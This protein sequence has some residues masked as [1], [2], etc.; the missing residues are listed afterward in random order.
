MK[1]KEVKSI[2]SGLSWSFGERILAQGITFGVSIILARILSPTEY[3]LIAL[4]LIFINLSNV[5][6]VSGL[7]EAL[8]QK[9]ETT[10]GDFSTMFWS[11][12]FFSIFIYIFLY[13]LS[14][15]IAK[16]YRK[17][18]VIWILRILALKLP[19]ASIN[20][21][22]RAYLSRRMEFKK[23]FFSTLGGTVISGIVGIILAYKGYGVWALVFQYITNSTIDT[24]VLFLIIN[25]KP[26][27]IFDINSAKSM[28]KYSLKI[29]G[30]SFINE[31][32]SEI[33]SLIIGRVYSPADLAFYN[34]GNQFPSLFITNINTS[35]CTVFFPVM[36]R[37]QDKKEE[38]KNLSKT[39]LIVSTY[40][41]FPLLMG[42]VGVSKN[43]VTVLLTEKWLPSVFYLN[44]LCFYWMVQPMQSVNW[45]ILKAVGRSDLCL[46]LE[47]IKKTIGFSLVFFTMF[48][49]VEAMAYST[50]VFAIISMLINMIPNG[51]LINY[52][53]YEQLKDIMINVFL[54][55]S[56]C[57]IVFI[58]GNILSFSNMVNLFLQILIG[59]I[60]YISIS[61]ILKI[62]SFFILK[63][64][65][66][67]KNK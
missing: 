5:F 49:S 16:L 33:R 64:K 13:N 54:S 3:G 38:L 26:K 57:L 6:V 24:L 25:W 46:K 59:V 43:L 22:Q 51:K 21:I 40:V 61:Y 63:D 41:I 4:V 11:S 42:L 50:T 67:S 39:T 45:Q 55:G 44:V 20:T 15:F 53:F 32:Y 65:I 34:R 14:P 28:I 30:A 29:M 52:Y 60:Y 27:L 31:L 37:L 9:S 10:D 66:L 56:M 7:G 2:I 35:I 1:K 12:L 8:I 48:I 62:E 17:D 19:L 18:E 36:S 58:S 47:I 23:F